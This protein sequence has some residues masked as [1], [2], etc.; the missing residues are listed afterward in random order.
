MASDW[1]TTPPK[2]GERPGSAHLEALEIRAEA[3]AH[4]LGV[5]A[6]IG[7]GELVDTMGAGRMVA[8]PAFDRVPAGA[9]VQAQ[10]RVRRGQRADRIGLQSLERNVCETPLADAIPELEGSLDGLGPQDE[11]VPAQLVRIV[12]L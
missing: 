6:E 2:G 8:C 3:F 7:E 12:A 10:L 9:E 5:E 1:L 11:L 4:N